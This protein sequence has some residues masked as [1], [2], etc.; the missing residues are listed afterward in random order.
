[1]MSMGIQMLL[2]WKYTGKIGLKRIPVIVNSITQA[3]I[4]FLNSETATKT[5]PMLIIIRRNV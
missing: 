1:M 5:A 4:W 2:S 3:L